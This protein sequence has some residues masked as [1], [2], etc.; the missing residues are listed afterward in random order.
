MDSAREHTQQPHPSLAIRDI[1]SRFGVLLRAER[2]VLGLIL[3]YA[4]AIGL[5]SLIVPLTVQELVNTFAFAIQPITIVTL[6]VIIIASLLFVGAFK[7]FQ[8][9]AEEILQRRLFARVA[10]GMTQHFPDVQ[11]AG[12]KPR[13]ANYFT[14]AVFMQRAL[15]GLLIDFIDVV[16]GGIV[17]MTIL[18]FYHPYFLGFNIVLFGGGA[19]VFVLLSQGGLKAT[20]EVSHWKYGTMHWLQE[21]AY[22]LLHFKATTCKP[23]LLRRTDEL[24]DQYVEARRTRFAVLMRQYLGSVVW[25]ALGHG[26]IIATA[27]W[28]LSIGQLTLGQLVAAQVIV[29]RLLFSFESLVKKMGHIFY[30]FTALT[31]L[32]FVF[33]LPKDEH[34]AVLS[35]PLPDPAIHGIRVTCRD[36]GVGQL[37]ASQLFEHFDLEI[38]PG[39]KVGILTGSNQ[40]KTTLARVLAGLEAPTS[41][42]IR[43]NGVDLRHLDLDSINA[44]RGFVLDSKLTLFEGSIEDNISLGRP[45]IT[46]SDLRWA[47]RFAE[48]EEE[49]DALPN[50]IKTHV[51]AE[52]VVFSPARI[53]KMLV[54]RA[55]VTRPQILIFDGLL[56]IMH[57]VQRETLLRRLCSKDEPWSA[58]FISND[59]ILTPYID[60]RVEVP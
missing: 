20:L 26:G 11:I 51:R 25:Q 48:L 40:A 33:S 52:G 8:V 43:Y 17:G 60:R 6:S 35:V 46:Y 58:V 16:I 42:V 10:L 1:M 55:I 59:P 9:Y 38:T 12:F 4:L 44:C 36:V 22:N 57:P 41:G 28:L 37:E 24:I 31:E 30:F 14:E 7:A 15:S 29:G 53:L 18:V 19:L 27:G 5:F 39:E 54:A 34:R 23:Y 50:G 49:I 47:L 56:H 45:S 2:R 21:I 32:D 3:S 13:Y